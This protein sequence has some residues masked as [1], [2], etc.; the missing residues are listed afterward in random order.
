[1]S[2]T[3]T[4]NFQAEIQQL[5]NIVIHSL[6]TDKEI[7][8]RELISNAADACE[9]LRFHQSS[10]KPILQSDVAP[11]I[12]ITTDDKA[13][14]ITIQDR[15]IGMTHGELVENLGTIAHSGTKAFLKQLAE[16]K[17]PDVGL[18][19]QFGVGFY[20]AFMVAKKVTVLSRSFQP[21]EQGWQWTSEGGAGYELTPAPD[22][23]R[24]TK[25]TL[26]LKD[27]AK[28]FAEGNTVERIIQRYSSFVP[29]PIELNGKRLN[30]VQ[31]IWARNKNEIKE[32]E[33]NEFYTFVGHDHDKPLYRLHFSADAP[34]A[35]KS[36]L[37]VPQRNF[38]SMGM[39]RIE[40]EVNLYCRKVLIQAKAK[41][42]FPEWLRFLKG[43]VDSE[44]L[45]L[46][47]SRET[48]QDTSLMQK[49]N[50]VLTG[51]FLKFLD[52]QAEK[53]PETYEKFYAEYQRF[54]K[55]GVV[56]DFTHKEALGKLLRFESSLLEKGKLTSLAD[57]VKRMSSEQ[58]EIYCLLAPNRAAAEA[59]PYFEVF[60]QRKFEVLFLFDPW[61]EF[62]VDHL[63][64]FDGKAVKL[65][66]K[67]ELDLSE[68][69]KEGAL[70]EDAA[71]SLAQWLK[72][73]LTDKV[74]EVRVSKRLV[75]SPAV[76]VDP[77]KFMTSSMRR[78]MKAMKKDGEEPAATKY[79]LEINP[80][81][82][83]L[84]RLDTMRQKD[85]ALAASVAEQ[86]LDNA[87]LAAGIVEDPRAMLSR[88]NQLLEKVLAKD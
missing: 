61:D 10:G 83:I 74:G 45:P 82:A 55:E 79:D 47:I 65:A 38:E 56:T 36:L 3:E 73:T 48:M 29:F 60:R 59:S 69:K 22:I 41:G 14:T 58:K 9:K 7:F 4:H 62:V 49:L 13:G 28:E 85:S 8:I 87:R 26:E 12:A 24:G 39:G 11:S 33:Y 27:D 40:S 18:I 6:Y 84:G 21:E 86:I 23:P 5:L 71:K 17:K 57:Y 34:L 88:L 66:E 72:D 25:I 19:G 76:L 16:D 78:I 35:I 30:T 52:E 50:K 42:L 80:A 43:V 44:D 51:R 75:D 1:M 70:S 31:A 67:A 81:H 54:L 2:K 20:S 63:Q 46:N 68:E 15:G 32:E 53:E 77:D 64:T 37:F